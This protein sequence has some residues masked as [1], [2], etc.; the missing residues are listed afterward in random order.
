[1]AYFSAAICN[2]A[3]KSIRT[4]LKEIFQTRRGAQTVESLAEKLNPKI[5]GWINYYSKF[6]KL[7][8]YGVFYYLNELMREWLKDKYRITS[9]GKVYQRYNVLH[10]ANPQLFY[11]WK[12]GI[13]A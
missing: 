11:H 8:A 3:K 6:G 2:A 4:V 13:K 9:K 12:L 1:M 7:K 10:T 5:R